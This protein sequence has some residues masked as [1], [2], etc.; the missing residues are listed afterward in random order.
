M[1][2]RDAAH[3]YHGALT[4]D[5]ASHRQHNGQEERDLERLAEQAFEA[6]E[7]V[8]AEEAPDEGGGE[9][10]KADPSATQHTRKVDLLR[11]SPRELED[12]L[13][14]LVADDVDDVVYRHDAHE[15]VRGIDDRDREQ[16]VAGDDL[17]HLLLIGLGGD[18]DRLGDHQVAEL[19]V[20]RLYDQLAKRQHADQLAAVV[21][22][23]DV[24][25]GLVVSVPL[26][27]LDGLFDRDRLGQ[28]EV[29]RRHD[30]AG[31]IGRVPQEQLDVLRELAKAGQD[32][33][34]QIT[35]QLAE[36]L[37]RVVG[38]HGFYQLRRAGR[39]E[40]RHQL[41]PRRNL[42]QGEHVG[43]D[44]LAAD[45]IED[46]PPVRARELVQ[47]TGDVGRVA[48][49][50]QAACMSPC[51]TAHEPEQADLQHAASSIGHE[52][53]RIQGPRLAAGA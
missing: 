44:L 48:L 2:C 53:C 3:D 37:C 38:R 19:L 42:E 28:G 21:D 39:V 1:P 25:A 22:H 10:G 27:P 6:V 12:V 11:R 13:G 50:E 8:N 41:G 29:L 5:V 30:R 46:G 4:A 7:Q 20:G 16:V 35:G 17:R 32:L 43:A 23:V 49:L 15:L 45:Q 47:D 9:P 40:L 24:E 36:Q 34:G 31:G 18:T 51:T 33:V 52:L 14:G 26:Q